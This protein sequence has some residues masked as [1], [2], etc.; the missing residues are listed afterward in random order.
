MKPRLHNGSLLSN[1]LLVAGGA[2]AGSVMTWS[3]MP[4]PGTVTPLSESESPA[5]EHAESPARISALTSRA[6]DHRVK[7]AQIIAADN[8]E[9]QAS[10]LNR[11]AREVAAED[12]A[13]ALE[14]AADVP[15][16]ENRT[17]FLRGA[18]EAWSK[19]DPQAATAYA[20]SRLPVGEARS[21]AIRVALASWGQ[22]DP[23]A[24][25]LWMEERLSGPMKEEALVALAQGWS[26]RA[27]QQAAAW[28][29][30][31][32][33]TSQPLLSAI[34]GSW[35]RQDAVAAVQWASQLPD[36]GNR[37]VGLTS[38]LGEIAR[39]D[40]AAAAAAAE[41]FLRPDP[42]NPQ[43]AA[44]VRD[45]ATVLAD[46]WGNTNPAAAAEWVRALPAGKDQL[47]AAGTLA[48]VWASSDIAAAV[49]W[50][51]TLA[52]PALKSAVVAHLG[53]TWG[54]IEPDRALAWLDSLPPETAARG[55]AGALNSWA[56]TDPV[57]LADWIE[58]LHPGPRGDQARRSLGDVIVEE[59]PAAALEL[60]AG[61]ANPVQQSDALARYYREFHRDDPAAATDWLQGEWSHFPA[62][63]R[64]A[65]AQEH[66]RL[67]QAARRTQP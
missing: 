35:A 13:T 28:F 20:E 67:L 59:Q 53:T 62:P 6:G 41:P 11:L 18:F 51:N 63:A 39:Q 1:L 14:M 4:R 64:Q 44:P 16:E 56:A 34:A 57:G 46:V 47:E 17:V 19:Q 5:S 54:A 25:F 27:P 50:T 40:P 45:L 48:T 26:S 10:D 29:I 2:L 42:A 43:A 31:T 38:A 37:D 33:S 15:G 23:R 60:A 61:M 52:D 65:L 24:A 66:Q 9:H 58:Q 12:P 3:L 36:P 49:A 55:T 21:E 7:L 32:G 22:S 8:P 30:E